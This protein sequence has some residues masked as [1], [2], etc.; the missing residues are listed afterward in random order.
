MGENRIF[1]LYMFFFYL[2]DQ[3]PLGLAQKVDIE[4]KELMYFNLFAYY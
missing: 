3:T 2:T 4:L 1:S